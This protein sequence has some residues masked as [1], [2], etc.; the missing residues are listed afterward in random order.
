[1]QYKIDKKGD[2]CV[3][4]MTGDLKASDQAT[5]KTLLDEATGSGATHY[6]VD[7]AGVAHIDSTGLG[8]LLMLQDV[9]KKN[10]G[11]VT[12]ANA[13]E[14]PRH[15]FGLARFDQLFTMA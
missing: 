1:M 15:A 9:A 2:E 4:T 3:V 8:L 5:Y 13:A 6:R 12:L 7:L 14:G 11:K 10:G